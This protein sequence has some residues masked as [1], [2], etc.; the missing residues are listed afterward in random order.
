VTELVRVCPVCDTENPPQRPRCSCG[1][2]LLGVDF[3]L[4]RAAVAPPPAAPVAES[5]PAPQPRICPYPDCAQPNA[6]DATRCAYCN[7]PLDA[8]AS[9][10]AEVTQLSTSRAPPP[11]AR[12]LPSALRDF[13]VVDVFPATGSEADILLV[14]RNTARERSVVKLYRKGIE[15]DFRLL[16]ILAATVGDTVVALRAHGVSDGVAYELLEYIPGGTL[17]AYLR[18]GP[19]S[20]GDVRA[21]VSEIAHALNG[22]HA[23]RILHRDLKPE[24]V[25]VR[26]RA[27]LRLALTDFGIASL[28]TATQHF[29]S[30]ARTTRYAAPELLTGVIDE[31]CDWW[32]LGMIA[33]EAATG[34]HPFDGLTEQ[35]M[36]HQLATRPIDV[37]GVYDDRLRT[38][39][40]GL[41]LRDPRRR[42][43]SD[44]VARWLADDPSLAAPDE[45]DGPATIVK[46]YRIGA[47][48]CTTAEE[49][50]LAMVRNWE[51]A[52]KDLAR[53][54]VA[55]WIEQELHDYNLLRALRDAQDARDR[56]DDA[57]LLAFLRAACPGL[58]P[59]WLGQ[60]L[61][62]EAILAQARRSLEDDDAQRWLDSL[63]RDGVLAMFD[64]S[65]ELAE[66][67]RRWRA[68]LKRYAELWRHTEQARAAAHAQASRRTDAEGTHVNFDDLVF[69]QVVRAPPP[70]P[71]TLH[72]ELLLA[73]F[74]ADYAAALRAELTTQHARIQ[75]PGGWFDALAEG[76]GD[77]VVGLLVARAFLDIAQAD[78][79]AQSQ[80]QA[81]AASAEARAIEEARIALRVRVESL[82]N[83]APED[84]DI[85]AGLARQLTESFD[86][87]QSVC[88]RLLALDLSGTQH[89]ALRTATEKIQVQGF[90]VQRTLAALER[91]RGV[92][93]IFL[94]PQR[95]GLAVVVAVIALFTRIAW[96]I[97]TVAVAI[98][99]FA[100][101]RWYVRFQSTDAVLAALRRFRLPARSFLAGAQERGSTPPEEKKKARR[102]WRA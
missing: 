27:P 60:P 15:P 12:P 9:A 74:D 3:S 41:L 17:E 4:P 75:A 85:D 73:L 87:L 40:R 25:L 48:Q 78:A 28:A 100:L 59:V 56:T 16:D 93:G 94:Q 34:R 35:V 30:A 43:G 32:S 33:L 47:A 98:A 76:V 39:C 77:E 52:R 2:S 38:L 46:P 13:H 81:A 6:P 23:H 26:S 79:A 72:G 92:T 65:E 84:E 42:W 36:N 21:I 8:G 7:R 62:R 70:D 37:R 90:A 5:P 14:E 63:W 83:L 57:R 97:A 53:G 51:D 67:D 10:R 86:D 99:G 102:L 61:S 71:A 89:E 55:R 18:E 44:E 49:L 24:N 88:Q 20:S 80:Q 58:P 54:Q 91:D 50:A 95:L 82:L 96:V 11:G 31:K 29:T 64:G 22:I 45:S 69:G 19:L 101:Y 66:V 1:A 68:A